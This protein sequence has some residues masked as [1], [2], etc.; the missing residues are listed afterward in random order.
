[1]IMVDSQTVKGGRS[2]PTFHEAG[3]KFGATVGAKRTVVVDYSGLP[4][5]VR[6]DSAR[7]HDSVAGRLLCV[8][9]LPKLPRVTHLLCDQGFRA[10]VAPLARR[11]GEGD[12]EEVDAKARG[13]QAHGALVAGGGLLCPARSLAPPGTVLRGDDRVANGMAPGGLRRLPAHEGLNVSV[14]MPT[15]SWAQ[16]VDR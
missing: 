6:V 14:P 11:R 2:G 7:P 13:L 9:A 15:P 4:V 3:G 12:R 16:D 8:S 5:T 1:M 10:L